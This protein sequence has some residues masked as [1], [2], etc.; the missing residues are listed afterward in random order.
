MTRR[1]F[2]MIEVMMATALLG[3]VGAGIAAFLSAMATGTS[4]RA[5]VSDPSLE[6][7]ITMRR[8]AAL[9]PG[10]RCAL[11]FRDDTVALW[12][13]DDVPSRTVHTSELGWLRFDAAAGEI[14]FERLDPAALAADRSLEA[15][16]DARTD[17]LALL[18]SLRRS[19]AV[20][21][22]AL[23]EGLDRANFVETR[24]STRALLEIHAGGATA[25]VALATA[26]EE[27]YR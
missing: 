4:A 19:A 2:T 8:L 1:G 17:F 20:R 3:V 14:V 6:G 25:R 12:L 24:D 22:I 18:E 26:G 16:H 10:V 21:T 15:E 27:P 9:A 11:E 7:A 5:R 23:S 13:H